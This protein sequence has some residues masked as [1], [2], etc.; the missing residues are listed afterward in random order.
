LPSSG[1]PHQEEDQDED[2]NNRLRKMSYKRKEEYEKKLRMMNFG[3]TARWKE[4][5]VKITT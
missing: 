4:L 1:P 3:R 2:G 5:I